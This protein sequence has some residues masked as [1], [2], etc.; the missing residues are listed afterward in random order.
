M[1]T[2]F[3]S[4][5]LSPADILLPAPHVDPAR[6]AV[7]ACDQ[8]TSDPA[9]WQRVESCVGDAPSTLRLTFP[10]IYL[11]EGFDRV[12]DIQR[13]MR[14]YLADGTLVPAVRDGFV[15]VERTIASGSRLG[16]MARVDGYH[17]SLSHRAAGAA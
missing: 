10:E 17:L 7:V 2:A 6:W 13:T 4:L 9:Y 5:G 14:A 16:L 15:L 11:S 12:A 1:S 3:D 8:H